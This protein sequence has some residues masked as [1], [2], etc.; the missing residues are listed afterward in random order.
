[1]V[2]ELGEMRQAVPPPLPSSVAQR[3]VFHGLSTWLVFKA[4]DVP[5]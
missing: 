4:A 2:T 3:G 1:M 5:V